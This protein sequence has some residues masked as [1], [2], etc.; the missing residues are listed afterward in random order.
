[1]TEKEELTLCLLASRTMPYVFLQVTLRTS[2][3]DIIKHARPIAVT[4][5]G[6]ERG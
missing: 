2:K 3:S 5:R 4:D 6:N 1:M